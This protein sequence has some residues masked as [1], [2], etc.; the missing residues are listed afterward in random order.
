[1]GEWYVRVKRKKYKK[2]YVI[3]IGLD[4]LHYED[5][6]SEDC[7]GVPT[8]IFYNTE[9]ADATLYALARAEINDADNAV[10][11]KEDDVD[12]V[13]EDI[14]K[15]YKK[16]GELTGEKINVEIIDVDK[17]AKKP[18]IRKLSLEKILNYK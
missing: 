15:F 1:V 12:R 14:Q 2:G 3:S 10:W 8:R 6:L 9:V 16:Y 4:P 5:C 11:V 17:I 7:K 18:K 13:L